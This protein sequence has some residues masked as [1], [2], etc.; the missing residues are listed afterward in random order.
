M[1]RTRPDALDQS[2][3]VAEIYQD[4]VPY[5][6][7]RSTLGV[8][9]NADYEH[10]VMRLLAGEGGLVRLEPTEVQQQLRREL[11]SPNPNVGLFRQFAACDAWVTIPPAEPPRKEAVPAEPVPA[12]ASAAAAA[13]PAPA[14]PPAAPAKAGAAPSP[15]APRR[16]AVPPSAA[17]AR[18]AAPPVAAPLPERT[19]RRGGTVTPLSPAATGAAGKRQA[20]AAE[21]G[22]E[23]SSPV[24]PQRAPMSMPPREPVA[25]PRQRAVPAPAS[26][27]FCGERLPK[28]KTVR[29]CPFC[30]GNQR[31]R[32]CPD[33]GEILEV[34]W[35]YCIACGH[36]VTD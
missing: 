3:T 27:P 5:R 11:G 16:A 10:A 7:V 4:L 22:L 36:A 35:R 32:P 1:R 23:P 21:P 17:P 26:C 33:C 9:L 30:G 13:A 24:L 14:A 19:V 2:I 34:N 12:S 15:P 20:P 6:R 31:T 25:Q 8:E 29:Y 28:A 18:K